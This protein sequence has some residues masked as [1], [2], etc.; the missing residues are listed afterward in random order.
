MEGRSCFAL[1]TQL[2][3]PTSAW[4]DPQGTPHTMRTL[5][6][7][8]LVA[9]LT[10]VSGLLASS[11]EQQ[12]TRPG[13]RTDVELVQIDLSVIDAE[14]RPVRGLSKDDFSIVDRQRSQ[15]VDAFSEISHAWARPGAAPPADVKADVADNSS[16]ISA[17]VVV[18]VIDDRNIWQG[19]AALVRDLARRLIND[20]CAKRRSRWCSRAAAPASSPRAIGPCCWLQSGR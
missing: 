14:G 4:H 18:L 15:R 13:F 19:R 16:A 17:R 20:L 5:T 11:P 9:G 2:E 6:V 10:L 3:R 8:A 1:A 7:A 12:P